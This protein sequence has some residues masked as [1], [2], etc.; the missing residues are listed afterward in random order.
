M[1]K[2]VVIEDN[3]VIQKI[4]VRYLRD[5]GYEAP[6]IHYSPHLIED[7]VKEAPCCI[8]LDINLPEMSG[9]EI[10]K[11]IKAHPSLVDTPVILNSSFSSRIERETAEKQSHCTLC[12]MKPLT[13]G[14]LENAILKAKASSNFEITPHTSSEQPVSS[15]KKTSPLSTLNPLKLLFKK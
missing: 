2:I 8:L 14:E 10:C 7:I 6:L 1:R 13:K 3:T 15:L 11:L 5:I 9:I 12:I 4:F